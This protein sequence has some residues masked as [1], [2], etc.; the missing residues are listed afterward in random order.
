[1]AGTGGDDDDDDDDND[2]SRR[3]SLTHAEHA[4]RAADG[5]FL[6]FHGHAIPRI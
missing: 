3:R 4:T 5:T 6:L 1:M 2:G